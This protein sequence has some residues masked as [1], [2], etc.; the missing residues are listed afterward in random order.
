MN[1]FSRYLIR[2]LFLGFAAAAGLLLPLF[3]TFNLINELDDV[4]P[5]GY[6]WTQAVLVVLMTLPRTLVELSPFIALLGGIVGLGQLSKN[7]ELTA[8]RSMG[9]SIF[10]IA[11]VALVAGI[12]WTVSL[13]AIDEWV[14]SPL[15][16]Q[17]LQIKSTA[18]ALGEDDDIT[19]NMLWARRGNEFV[20]VKSLNE[21]AVFVQ[22]AIIVNNDGTI[23]AAA[24]AQTTG[25]QIFDITHET[26]RTRTA[27]L[28]HKRISGEVHR[29]A[30]VAGINSRMVK[31]DG[32]I[33]R[34][35]IV[36]L[37]FSPL[38]AIF[39]TNSLFDANKFFGAVQLVDTGV[40]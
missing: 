7:S 33:Q 27:D 22:Y 11:L 24:Q 29:I 12:L 14:A 18:T 25:L 15:Q 8:I 34:K 31:I 6:R 26:E 16:Q 17:A 23:E 20:T 19:G 28:A 5:G 37:K 3:T 38:I 13:G 35:T 40:K 1:V 21:Q 36:R 2:H 30:L 9:F 4:S 10:R 32:E 39:D